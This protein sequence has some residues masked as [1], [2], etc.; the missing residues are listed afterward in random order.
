[1]SDMVC[2]FENTLQPKFMKTAFLGFLPCKGRESAA[3]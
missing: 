2:G 3:S 1:M